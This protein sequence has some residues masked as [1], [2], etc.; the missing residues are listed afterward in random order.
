MLEAGLILLAAGSSTRMGSAKQLMNFNGK[1]LLRHA[2]ELACRSNCAPVIVV[3][4]A[5]EHEMRP[6]LRDL[7]LE[8]VVNDS[9]SEGIGTSIKT[10]LRAL[11][12][13]PVS[14]VILALADQPFITPEFLHNLAEKHV[15]TQKLIVASRYSGTVGVPAFFSRQLFPRLQALEPHQGCKSILLDCSQEAFL[16][17]CPEA[18]LDIDS[19]EDYLNATRLALD[20]DHHKTV[21]QDLM[22]VPLRTAMCAA[23]TPADP[24][25]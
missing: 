23:R 1:P 18:V 3:L 10:A 9:W 8:I 17:D 15:R 5:R 4:G 6:A 14:G 2:A 20:D 24:A 12:N 22:S 19:P 21:L 13:R 16:M 11:E 7:S 25:G